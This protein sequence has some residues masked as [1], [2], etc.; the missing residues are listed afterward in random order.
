M[1]RQNSIRRKF[2]LWVCLVGL[3]YFGSRWLMRSAY[4]SEQVASRLSTSVGALV[5]FQDIDLGFTGSTLSGVEVQERNG[6]GSSA[7]WLTIGSVDVDL[8]LWQLWRGTVDDGGVTLRDVRVVLRFDRDGKLLTRFPEPPPGESGPMPVVRVADGSVTIRREGRPDETIRNIALEFRD[9]GIQMNLQGSV[10][11]ADWGQWAVLGS[12]ASASAPLA[13]N[14]K[15]RQ[16]VHVTPALLKRTPFVTSNVWEHVT[17]EGDTPCELALQFNVSQSVN[18][19]V[20]L[21]PRNT[22]VYVRSIDLRSSDA[23]GTVVIADDVLTLENV[24]GH[25]AGGELKLKSM[26][27]FR[28]IDT[29]MKFTIQAGLLSLTDLPAAWGVPALKG[30]LNGKAELEVTSK[31]GR[32]IIRGQGEGTVRIFPLLRAIKVQLVSD[33]QRL[34]FHLGRD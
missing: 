28:G 25:A 4:A 26:M 24:R 31:N 7:P 9:D 34:K 8:S 18:Y 20:T 17:C 33:G 12:K 2:Y 19:R 13:F 30:E 6:N 21:E 15:T 16:P 1:R 5:Q 3:A 14:F 22:R 32:S 10:N 27:D 23:S 29:I 11:D